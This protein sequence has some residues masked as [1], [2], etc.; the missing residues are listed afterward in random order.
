MYEVISFS[1]GK[2]VTASAKERGFR[3]GGKSLYDCCRMEEGRELTIF[4]KSVYLSVSRMF[5][6]KYISQFLIHKLLL[7]NEDMQE[8]FSN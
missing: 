5:A 4:M 1:I 6:D 2:I 8:T 7:T 3:H